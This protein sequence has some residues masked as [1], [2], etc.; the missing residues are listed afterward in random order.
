M[1]TPDFQRR[2]RLVAAVIAVTTV[3]LGAAGATQV[4]TA[5]AAD[6]AYPVKPIPLLVPFAP[7][8]SQDVVARLFGQRVG[9]T[10]GQQVV[11]DNRAGAGGLIAAQEVAR[12]TADGY[13]L[14]LSGGAQIA[15]APSLNAKLAYD[16]LKDFVAYAKA[17]PGKVNIA[18]TG[19]GIYTHL[20]LELFKSITDTTHV[21][22]KGAAPALTD[23][24][25]RQIQGM[26]TTTTSAQPYTST[27]RV[28]ALGVTA[29]QRSAML[30]DVPTFAAAGVPNLN[31][32]SWNGVSVPAGSPAVA[33][34]R[35]SDAF[36][37]ALQSPTIRERLTTL[38][39]VSAGETSAAFTRM[40]QADIT[41]W[42]KIIKLAG[43]S[44]D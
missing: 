14:L 24:I 38:G 27:S 19:R 29:P 2:S 17:N 10:L 30:P 22:Y 4:G 3:L 34:R 9:E 33:M 39:A 18:S 8:G 44:A 43:I 25:G 36:A 20:T 7:G 13:T 11:I 37:E 32:S 23:I 28:R 40:V 5:S 15:I 21:P 31:V 1:T 35:L 6:I 12:A 42:A 26:F 16:P 41:R